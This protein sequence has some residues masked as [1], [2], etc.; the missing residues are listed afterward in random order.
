MKDLS[1]RKLCSPFADDPTVPVIDTTFLDKGS[2]MPWAGV[3]LLYEIFGY[4]FS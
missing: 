4:E 2:L 1:A 3:L